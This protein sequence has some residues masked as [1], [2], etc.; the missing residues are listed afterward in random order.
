MLHYLLRLAGSCLLVFTAAAASAQSEIH[1]ASHNY[2]VAT[3]AEGLLQPW[4]MA[5][6]PGGDMLVTEKPGRLRIIRDGRLLPEAVP[7]LPEVFYSGQGGLFE[8]LP[9]P[10]FSDNR[11]IYLSYAKAEGETSVTAVIRGRLEN[12]RL[13]NVV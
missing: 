1:Y 4:S 8:V 10:N 7:G 2:R 12:D 3:V 6:L 9:H 11:W 5:W 13:S